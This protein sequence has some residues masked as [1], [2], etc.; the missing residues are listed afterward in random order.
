[1]FPQEH[2]SQMLP[3]PS[4]C[5]IQELSRSVL[6]EGNEQPKFNRRGC[7]RKRG[8]RPGEEAEHEEGLPGDDADEDGERGAQCSERVPHPRRH[9]HAGLPAASASRTGWERR[10][11][12]A[13]EQ[14]N[15]EAKD[16]WRSDD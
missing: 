3:T 7:S 16:Y 13:T 14:K 11:L 15:R 6:T 12:R 8:V 2:L 10:L 1:M 9:R 4:S 5:R